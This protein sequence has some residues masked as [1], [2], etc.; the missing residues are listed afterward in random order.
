M[1]NVRSLGYSDL[2]VLSKDDLWLALE[3]FPEAK[4][5]LIEAGKVRLR[6]VN[7]LSD[8]VP[9]SFILYYI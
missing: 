4:Q 5:R 9:T 2:F 6:E 7:L 8:E 1:A 3:E